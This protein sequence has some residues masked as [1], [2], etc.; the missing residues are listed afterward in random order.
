MIPADIE[1]IGCN[2][3]DLLGQRFEVAKSGILENPPRS[4][5]TQ[6]LRA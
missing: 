2:P 4:P 6:W 3:L 5:L 1:I